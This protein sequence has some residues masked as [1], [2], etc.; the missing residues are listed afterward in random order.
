MI[1]NSFP[2]QMQLLNPD[3]GSSHPPQPAEYPQGTRRQPISA[4]HS[5]STNQLLINPFFT[6]RTAVSLFSLLLFHRTTLW[7]TEC[8]PNPCPKE[9]V[10]EALVIITY[11]CLL[12][13]GIISKQLWNKSFDIHRK[14]T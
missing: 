13:R 6:C 5:N 10:P 8:T 2:T 1:L 7:A 9:H 14:Y 4:E 12:M 11:H 3:E